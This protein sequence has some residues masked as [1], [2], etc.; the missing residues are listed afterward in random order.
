[1]RTAECAA[2][3]VRGVALRATGGQGGRGVAGQWRI[4]HK[5]LLGLGL[6]VGVMAV[7]LAGTVLGLLSYRNTANIMESKV[8]ELDGV[9]K[10]KEAITALARGEVVPGTKSADDIPPNERAEQFFLLK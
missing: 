5:L 3:G 2:A 1:M 10:F 8:R 7:L 4:R 9:Q 6:V